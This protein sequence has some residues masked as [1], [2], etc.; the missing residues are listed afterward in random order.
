V[1]CMPHLGFR[2]PLQSARNRRLFPYSLAEG[3]LAQQ[4][5]VARGAPVRRGPAARDAP[6]VTVSWGFTQ[7]G[8]TAPND[9]SEAADLKSATVELHTTC[10]RAL[11]WLLSAKWVKLH[12][13]KQFVDPS[14]G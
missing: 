9:T 7:L 14:T 12:V 6:V 5:V 10:Q 11:Q 13:Q 8:R 3:I 1:C 4:I 2:A